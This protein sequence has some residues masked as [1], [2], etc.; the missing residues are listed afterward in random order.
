VLAF[1][2]LVKRALTILVLLCPLAAGADSVRT[3]T[4]K[5]GVVHFTNVRPGRKGRAGPLATSPRAR[6]S[7]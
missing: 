6:A 7:G 1:G 5:D 3:W 2:V 4:D